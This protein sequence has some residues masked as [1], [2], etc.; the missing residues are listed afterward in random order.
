MIKIDLSTDSVL[1]YLERLN[2]LA[3]LVIFCLYLI[4]NSIGFSFYNDE[5]IDLIYLWVNGYDPVWK[6]KFESNKP[7]GM[8]RE[9]VQDKSW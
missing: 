4:T 3:M 6:Q 8:P 2:A 7:E 9:E 5:K 1:H